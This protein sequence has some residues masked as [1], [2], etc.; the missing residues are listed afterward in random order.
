MSTSKFPGATDCEY[1]INHATSFA[2]FSCFYN[3]TVELGNF[4]G[5]FQVKIQLFLRILRSNEHC[6]KAEDINTGVGGTQ[7]HISYPDRQVPR[8]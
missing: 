6:S 5:P 1:S 2:L 4:Q 8:T 7:P 3:D